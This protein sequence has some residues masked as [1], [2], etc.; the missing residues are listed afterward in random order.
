MATTT[1]TLLIAFHDAIGSLVTPTANFAPPSG[2]FGLANLRDSR[3]FHRT[4]TPDLTADRQLTWDLGAAVEF[5]V[6]ML[7]GA[8]A[9]LAATRRFR[10]A[11][12][13]G[14]TADVVQSGGTLEAAFDQ[15]LGT[16]VA[17]AKPWGRL[18][19][20][21]HSETVSRRYL[22]WHQSDATNPDGFQEWGVARVGKAVQFE[23]N[24]WLSQPE[25]RGERGS[26]VVAGVHELTLHNLSKQQ[27][28]DMQSLALTLKS[29][30]R[31]LVIPEP[32]APGTWLR[33]AVWGTIEDSYVR[34]P[35]AWTS[36]TRKRY[37]T[38]VRVR[39]VER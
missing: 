34:E 4:R 7:A 33:D 27:A 2:D 22:R 9:T 10:S 28:Y 23:F 6:F 35:Q 30:R 36:Y 13:S 29:S 8:N 32:R 11:S 39:E 31:V 20:Y 17:P 12:D 16:V 1:N 37:R 25:P 21:V 19:I 18:L 5:N 26:Q 14:F 3:L 24:S 38:V 15:S